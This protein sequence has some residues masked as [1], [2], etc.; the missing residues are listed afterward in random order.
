MKQ[1]HVVTIF[2]HHKGK[3]CL[4]RRSSEVRTHKG[5]WSGISGYLEGDPQEHFMVE[6][7][8]ETSLTPYEYTLVRHAQPIDIPDDTNDQIWCVH[9]FLCDVHDPSLIRLD[10]ENTELEWIEPGEMRNKDTVPGLL[11]VYEKVSRLPLEKEV[12]CFKM[13]ISA[14][15]DSGAH[16]IAIASLNFLKKICE[17]T[18]AATSKTLIEDIEFVCKE[19]SAVRPSMA[20]ISTTLGLLF[21]DISSASSLDI[22]PALKRIPVI[23][24]QHSQE[25]DLSP[26]LAVRHLRGIIQEGSAVLVHS[27]S[28]CVNAAFRIL[29]EKGCSVVVT[30]SRPG[31]E[32]RR[33]AMTALEMGLKVS[34]ITDALAAYA[35]Q[36]V[37]MVLLGVDSIEQDGSV[38][39][40]AGSMQIAL[41]ANAE[42]VKVYCLGELRKICIHEQAV[43]LEE[44]ETEEVWQDAPDGILVRNVYFDR[45]APRYITGII[46]EKDIVEPYQ[47]RKIARSLG[48]FS[49]DVS[50][51]GPLL[52]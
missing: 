21:R 26:K 46:L 24:E 37:D 10:W 30:E 35:L 12:E 18:N 23:I 43:Q 48:A 27:Y 6:L 34:L 52:L 9:P 28:S 42:G 7:Q 45:T 13:Q 16:Q 47:I 4:V 3:I 31:L 44:H 5:R 41:A 20:I 32:G 25:M 29:K 1:V 40:K 36:V 8:E 38:I 17:I 15:R 19:L 11:E 22:K 50:H 14:D 33:T 51:G 39:N 2:M 49:R